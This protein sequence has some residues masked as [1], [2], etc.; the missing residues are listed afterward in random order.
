MWLFWICAKNY[1]NHI[2]L[3]VVCVK[4]DTDDN[5]FVMFFMNNEGEVEL[6]GVDLIMVVV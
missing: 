2:H 6:A 5:A 3:G 1:R 4:D